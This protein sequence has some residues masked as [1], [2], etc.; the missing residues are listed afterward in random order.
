MLEAIDAYDPDSGDGAEELCGELGD[1]LYQV[2]F[3]SAIAEEAGWFSL[4]DVADAIHDKLVATS[5]ARVRP[6]PQ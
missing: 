2:V 4:G 1:L 5:R 3:H 6:G